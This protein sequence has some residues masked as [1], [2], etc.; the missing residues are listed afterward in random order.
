MVTIWGALGRAVHIYGG[1]SGLFGVKPAE[2][3]N[4]SL[5]ANQD[6]QRTRILYRP[7][8]TVRVSLLQPL[9]QPQRDRRGL[10]RLRVIFGHLSSFYIE[11]SG[12][13]A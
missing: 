3:F 9:H 5:L 6:S 1:L 4:H 12:S 8:K 7:R 2:L 10:K 13:T 11:G